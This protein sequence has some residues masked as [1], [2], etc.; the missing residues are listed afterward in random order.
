MIQEFRFQNKISF[1][2]IKEMREVEGIAVFN[3]IQK[4]KQGFRRTL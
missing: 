2:R 1:L 3:T 4:W